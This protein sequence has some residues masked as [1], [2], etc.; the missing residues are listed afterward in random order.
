MDKKNLSTRFRPISLFVVESKKFKLKN[1]T[2]Q[3][4]TSLRLTISHLIFR[5]LIFNSNSANCTRNN[6]LKFNYFICPCFARGM[7]FLFI[8]LMNHSLVCK[9]DFKYL[10]VDY[11]YDCFLFLFFQVSRLFYIVLYI[12]LI[13]FRIRPAFLSSK[14]VI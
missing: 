8:C 11:N 1:K 6:V 2:N 13:M 7:T 9:N 12:L 3:S 14:Q 5:L 4:N 10:L